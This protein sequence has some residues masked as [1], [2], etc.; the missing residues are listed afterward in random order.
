MS[1]LVLA[2]ARITYLAAS[3][4]VAPCLEITQPLFRSGNLQT[5]AHAPSVDGFLA[6]M[7]LVP[8][9]N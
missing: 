5:V 3:Y 7:C 9:M 2:G 8:G 4:M 1:C 6:Q